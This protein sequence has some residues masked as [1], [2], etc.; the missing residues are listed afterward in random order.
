MMEHSRQSIPITKRSDL[1]RAGRWVVKIGSSLTTAPDA[2]PGLNTELISAWVEQMVALCAHDLQ[3]SI[4]TSGAV[5]EGV[6][7]LGWAKRPHDLPSLQAAAAVGQM[8]LARVYQQSFATHGVTAAQ[9]LLT[10]DDIANRRRYL[11]ARSTLESLLEHKVVPVIN[12]NDTVA[13]EELAVGDND[14]LAGSVCNLIDASVLI[15][16]TDQKGLY[17]RDP[18]D[19]PTARLLSEADLSD[20]TLDD[21]AGGS[22]AWGRGGM[23]TKLSAARIAARSS[24]TT[25][26]VGGHEANVLRRVWE[27]DDIGTLLI[28]P[29]SQ[30]NAWRQWL[31]GPQKITG[32]LILDAGAVGVVKNDGRSVLAVGIHRAEGDFQRGQVVSIVDDQ[33]LE[34]GRGLTN[35]DSSELTQIA[36]K[37]SDQ[38]ETVL[39][40]CREEEVIHRDNLVV[41]E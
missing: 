1:K 10:H 19:D 4:V 36:G 27:G 16:L 11:N 21:L 18:R 12:E 17:E 28:P 13:T 34:I 31:A 37:P 26:I 22:G 29:S 30:L 32:R 25:L 2:H 40:F 15:I 9:V 24:T 3:F 6:R 35:Y 14:T 8:G 23:K 7:Q 33:G 38:I 5:A 41:L 39:G 20:P